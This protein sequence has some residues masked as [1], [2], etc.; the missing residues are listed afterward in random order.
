MTQTWHKEHTLPELAVAGAEVALMVGR[1]REE[2]MEGFVI[3]PW[4]VG[5]MEG[6]RLGEERG[7]AYL[8][9]GFCLP[10]L[11]VLSVGWFM[12]LMEPGVASSLARLFRV[13]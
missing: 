7:A 8:G 3:L 2:G 12:R 9:R 11:L 13:G 10:S 1:G 4:M 5:E 6:M